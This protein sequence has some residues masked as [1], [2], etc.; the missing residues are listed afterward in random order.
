MI[1]TLRSTQIFQFNKIC[2]AFNRI[3]SYEMVVINYSNVSIVSSVR[4]SR[5]RTKLEISNFCTQ[6]L[7]KYD[8]CVVK[9]LHTSPKTSHISPNIL[10]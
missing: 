7:H 8:V 1:L 3:Y 5:K 6:L 4:G 10:K 2:N 9:S